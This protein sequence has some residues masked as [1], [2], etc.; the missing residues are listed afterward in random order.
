MA[1]SD[2]GPEPVPS[3]R[4]GPAVP[5]PTWR[6]QL[7]AAY[8]EFR[9]EKEGNMVSPNTLRYYDSNLKPFL[10]WTAA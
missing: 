6:S 10:A 9:S 3:L 8:E 5:P 4:V 1:A 2:H 7:Q